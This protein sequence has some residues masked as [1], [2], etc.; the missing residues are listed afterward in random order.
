[1]SQLNG[2]TQFTQ[3]YIAVNLLSCSSRLFIKLQKVSFV[4]RFAG[5]AYYCKAAIDMP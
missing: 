2:E 5:E 4:N 1:M 3:T